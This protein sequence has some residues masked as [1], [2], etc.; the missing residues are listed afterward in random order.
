[1]DIPTFIPD[2]G[3]L[4]RLSKPTEG[5]TFEPLISKGLGACFLC[6]EGNQMNISFLSSVVKNG[7]P[8]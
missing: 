1:M 8:F 6:W 4:G 3:A 2:S 5:P 7:R